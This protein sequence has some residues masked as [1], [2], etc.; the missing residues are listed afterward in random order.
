MLS[1]SDCPSVRGNVTTALQQQAGVL[2]VDPNLMP[3]H[4]VIDIVR[5]D[6]AEETL[7][8]VAKAAIAGNQC[9]VEIMKSC[10]TAEPSHART[11]T[12]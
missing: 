7:T 2:L 5:Q 11:H 6:L 8:A 4:M 12:P 10:I 9:R 3:D 1:G